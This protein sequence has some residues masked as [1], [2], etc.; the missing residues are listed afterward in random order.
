L[1][2]QEVPTPRRRIAVNI[3]KVP[4]LARK[5]AS[6]DR[7]NNRSDRF[8]QPPKSSD[9]WFTPKCSGEIPLIGKTAD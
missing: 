1:F 3:A 4:E 2:A 8:I 7:G 5:R 9:N 6:P